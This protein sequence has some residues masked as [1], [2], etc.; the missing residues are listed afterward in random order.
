LTY[1]LFLKA[2]IMASFNHVTL[3]GNLTRDVE[4]RQTQQGTAV[5]D[6]SL[7]VN[8]RVKSGEQWVDQVS[9]FDITLWGRLAEVAQQ[10]LVK[11]NPVL[12][13]GRLK[14]ERWE[15]EGQKRSNVKV[16]A[17]ELKLIGGGT[18]ALPTDSGQS[19]Q[20]IADD[21]DVPF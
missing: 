21:D 16:I 12:I 9:F 7:A 3:M 1:I 5:A 2:E 10:Y 19:M 14:Q 17:S 11:G 8:E 20:S 18:A 6:I 15:K 13:S 4:L